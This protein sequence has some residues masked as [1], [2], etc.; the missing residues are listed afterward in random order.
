TGAIRRLDDTTAEL[1]RMWLLEP[2]QGRG[3]GW[4][5]WRELRAFASAAGYRRIRLT[6]SVESSRANRCYHRLGFDLIERYND[7]TEGI[8]ME[9]TLMPRTAINPPDLF[10]SEP[11]GFSQVVVAEGRRTVYCSGQVS[12]DEQEDIGAPGDLA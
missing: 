11:Y 7:S 8:F 4:R 9:K 2:Y 1:R 5:M 6:T 10:A 3:I 12:W